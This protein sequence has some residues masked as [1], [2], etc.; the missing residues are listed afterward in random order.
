MK[1]RID[2]FI[3]F[4]PEERAGRACLRT[5]VANHPPVPAKTAPRDP[6]ACRPGPS[7]H[8]RMP[9]HAMFD[10]FLSEPS[11]N[12]LPMVQLFDSHPHRQP[13]LV[14]L[15]PLS[16]CRDVELAGTSA[17]ADTRQRT[18]PMSSP[19]SRLICSSGSGPPAPRPVQARRA[20]DKELLPQQCSSCSRGDQPACFDARQPADSVCR[21]RRFK[22]IYERRRPER[23]FNGVPPQ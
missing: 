17:A 5:D 18:G 6:E 7:E 2:E 4:G 8:D 9:T 22:R 20:S 21:W 19:T 15:A 23:Q 13:D 14:S 1:S 11:A 3:S 16:V 12:D 10:H